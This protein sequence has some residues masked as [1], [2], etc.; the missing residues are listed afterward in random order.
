[1]T[2]LGEDPLRVAGEQG[3]VDDPDKWNT[4]AAEQLSGYPFDDLANENVPSALRHSASSGS[5]VQ[6]SLA[7]LPS[8]QPSGWPLRPKYC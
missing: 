7:V 4:A 1:M 6:T 5:F 2:F 8:S 3:I